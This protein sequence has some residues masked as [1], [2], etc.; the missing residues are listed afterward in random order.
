MHSIGQY[1]R[2]KIHVNLFWNLNKIFTEKDK[3]NVNI[4]IKFICRWKHERK[5]NGAKC[6]IWWIECCA[7]SIVS[8]Q[9]KKVYWMLLENTFFSA[10]LCFPFISRKLNLNYLLYVSIWLVD[11]ACCASIQEDLTR[12]ALKFTSMFHYLSKNWIQ[13]NS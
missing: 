2:A 13:T 7:S 3:S 4:K 5:K 11:N 1:W 12:S 8:K 6:N 10:Y 9:K